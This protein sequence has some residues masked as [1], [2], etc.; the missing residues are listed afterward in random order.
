M[1][2]VIWLGGKRVKPYLL[3]QIELG[4]LLEQEMLIYI[5]LLYVNCKVV[6]PYMNF[7]RPLPVLHTPYVIPFV[8]S[9]GWCWFAHNE[10]L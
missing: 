7:S 1:Q 2:R 8:Y 3:N 6:K 9:E 10:K 4:A 5:G